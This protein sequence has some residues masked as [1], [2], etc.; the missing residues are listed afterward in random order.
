[1]ERTRLK[2]EELERRFA[3][4]HPPLTAEEAR[5]QA[6]R[7]LFCFDAPCTRACPTHIDVP[8]FIKRI[9][10]RNP[11]GAAETIL[12]ANVL[13]GS[14]ARVCPTEVLCEGACVD[15]ALHG[16]PI[17]IGALQRHAVDWA[18]A[19][20][21]SFFEPGPATGSRVAVVGGGPAGLACAFE[22]RR[23]GHAVTVLEASDLPGGLNAVGIAA[24]KISTA[25]ALAEVERVRAMGAEIRL[26]SRIDAPGISRLLSEND[27]VFLAI[28]LGRTAPL[29]I[30]GEGGEEVCEALEFI[31]QTH[32]KPL[33][34]CSVGRRVVVIG[35]GNTAID[36]A[37]AATRLG[38]EHVTIAYRR[39]AAEM[40][41]FVHEHELATRDGVAFAW[42]VAPVE[43]VHANGALSGL[44]MQHL[45]MQGEGRH[46]KLAPIAGSDFTLECDMAVKALG[47]EPLLDLLGAI[48]GLAVDRGRVVIDPATGATSVPGLFAGGD[49]TSKGAEVVNAVQE[50]KVAAR[51]IDGYL[52]DRAQGTG[53]RGPTPAHP[54]D[55]KEP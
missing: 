23:Q 55:R 48:P 41:A 37:A 40:P 36:V 7:C 16:A 45:S 32:R 21:L 24:Y 17:P 46:A 1:M 50:G 5:A 9:L 33:A 52:K 54:R 44:R 34:E 18:D 28:G 2:G 15:R 13:G 6:A 22:L 10:H 39:T 42:L 38:A 11:A 49:C 30:P 4:I 29:G 20:G 19:R 35:G 26:D 14:C 47:Q 51:G 53:V 3:E 27:A 31:A 25:F 8:R 12:D 43:F